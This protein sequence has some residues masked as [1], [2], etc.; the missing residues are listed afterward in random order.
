MHHRRAL[1]SIPN[2][3]GGVLQASSA[4]APSS[5]TVEARPAARSTTARRCFGGSQST[6]AQ[7]SDRR[8]TGQ[9]G[10]SQ[11]G[12]DRGGLAFKAHRLVYHSTLGSRVIG[13]KKRPRSRRPRRTQGSRG[14]RGRGRARGSR[15]QAR[16]PPPL[17]DRGTIAR[18]RGTPTCQRAP[19]FA[20]DS[21]SSKSRSCLQTGRFVTRC[22]YVE[23]QP[24]AMSTL[25]LLRDWY[26]IAE[27]PH[28]AHPEGCAALRIVL[29]TVPR[30]SRSCEQF[31][32][33]LDHGALH[34]ISPQHQ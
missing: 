13:N 11:Q 23:A 19:R 28:L 14:S 4:C 9:E 6:E 1:A 31:P 29:V 5:S 32:D 18:P 26:F 10:T 22:S 27:Q 21:C 7:V 3:A 12:Q 24:V 30:V 8:Q 17:P 34:R 25:T 2:A 16:T 15:P 33:G 20:V